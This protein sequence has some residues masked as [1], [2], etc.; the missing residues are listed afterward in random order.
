MKLMY[1]LE[2]RGQTMADFDRIPCSS[3]DDMNDKFRDR[4]HDG[5]TYTFEIIEYDFYWRLPAASSKYR[6][7]E[8]TPL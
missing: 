1:V 3:F 4:A 2:V 5:L 6:P 8:E 7:Y